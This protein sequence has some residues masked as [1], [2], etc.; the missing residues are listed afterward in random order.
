[1]GSFAKIPVG[2]S[3]DR[4]RQMLDA[5]GLS[6]GHAGFALVEQIKQVVLFRHI[7][8]SGLDIAGHHVGTGTYLLSDFPADYLAE[9][10][11]GDYIDS[12]PLVAQ[13]KAGH[14]ICRDSEA[15]ATPEAR[16]AALEVLDLLRRHAIAERT[17]LRVSDGSKVSGTITV[18]SEKRLPDDQ[19]LLLQHFA[20]SLHAQ[21]AK[22]VLGELNRK[23]KLTPGEIYCLDHAARGLTS[24]EIA[25]ADT[26]SVDTVNTYLKTATR[27]LGAHNRTQAVAE[28]IRR[29]LID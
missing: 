13:F 19:C 5:I 20:L 10:Y 26:Y 1:M 24:E 4:T 27:K 17:I 3:A 7:L 12:D 2:Q 11:A 18:I 29:R 16:R 9:Y 8:I 25:A 23:L 21:V 6:A 22:P 15:F 14:T 28:G